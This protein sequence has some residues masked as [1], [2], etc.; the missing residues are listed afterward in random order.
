[1]AVEIAAEVSALIGIDVLV[2]D[3]MATPTVAGLARAIERTIVEHAGPDA[4]ARLAG[5]DPPK[6]GA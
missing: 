3:L 1:M 2:A 6:G 5:D 4:I